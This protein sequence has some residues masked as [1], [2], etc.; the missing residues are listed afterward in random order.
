MKS[1]NLFLDDVRS[2]IFIKKMIPNL[3]NLYD[4][5]LPN[6]LV[7]D[8]ISFK[9]CIDSNKLPNFV[10]FDHDLAPDHYNDPTMDYS[11]YK[12]KTG[13]T[14]AQYL[15]EYCVEN[16]LKFPTYYIHSMNFVGKQN[17]EK[18]ITSYKKH[19]DI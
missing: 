18:L 4:V 12:E 1:Y 17:I 13:L 16:K 7:K 9:N 3:H 10:S 14:C 11:N 2:V 15:L 19:F 6:I 8:Y 5:N